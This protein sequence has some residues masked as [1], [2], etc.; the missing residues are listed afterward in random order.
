[1]TVIFKNVATPTMGQQ[2]KASTRFIPLSNL[3]NTGKGYILEMM[4]SGFS[5]D[6]IEIDLKEDKLTI[7]GQMPK[8]SADTIKF[9]RRGLKSGDFEATYTL[10]ERIEKSAIDAECHNGLLRIVLPLKEEVI[11][12]PRKINIQ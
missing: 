5:K 3:I 9:I 11:A 1:M 10:S 2:T 12:T 8:A 6:D 4:V 7:K